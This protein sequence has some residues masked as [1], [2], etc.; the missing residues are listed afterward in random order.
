MELSVNMGEALNVI[1]RNP[2]DIVLKIVRGMICKLFLRRSKGLIL[3]GK[4]VKIRQK[5]LISVGKNFK[6]E[7]YCEIQG[8]AK[9]GLTFGD[10][11]TI[12]RMAM[13]RPSGY[14]I[15]EIG[16]GLTVGNNSAIGASCFIG[17]SGKITIGDNVMLGPNVNMLGE[18]HV[19]EDVNKPIK[20]QG[21]IREEI[22][23]EDDCWIGS[24]VTILAGIRIGRGSIIAAGAVVTK[25]VS[26]YTIVGGVPAKVIKS[27]MAES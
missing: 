14:Y 21:V 2:V 20:E 4:G 19:F 5:R 22:V 6:A 16:E 9:E 11:V 18:N 1:L 8:L 13:I 24:G 25:N 15:G 7:D 26:P 3:I 12:G 17:A 23:I 27:R 10:N